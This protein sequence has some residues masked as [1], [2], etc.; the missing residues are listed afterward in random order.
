MDGTEIY[1]IT[2]GLGHNNDSG[3]AIITGLK[4]GLIEANVKVL[5]ILLYF[6]DDLFVFF[7]LRTGYR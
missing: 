5:F 2:L 3:M 4:E 1:N 6:M 7:T